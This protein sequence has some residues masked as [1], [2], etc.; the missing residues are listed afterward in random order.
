MTALSKVLSD[1]QEHYKIEK[2]GNISVVYGDTTSVRF[3]SDDYMYFIT[4]TPIR[5]KW[6]NDEDE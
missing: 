5:T 4:I 2:T 6:T 1:I 3:D